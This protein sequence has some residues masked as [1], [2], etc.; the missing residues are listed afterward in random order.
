[1]AAAPQS[2]NLLAWLGALLGE[3]LITDTAECAFY[4]GD[5]YT[6]GPQPLAVLRPASTAELS[7]AVAMVAPHGVALVPRG[8]GMSYTGGYV[9]P[10]AGALIVDLG[11][12]DRVLAISEADMTATVEAGCTWETLRRAL[13]PRKLRAL[14]WGTLSGVKATVGGGMSQNGVFWGARDGTVVDG[15]LSFEVVLADGRIVSTGSSF[16]RPFGPD[17]TGL[18]GADAGA[19]GSRRPP[20]CNW[21]GR[22][23]RL[24]MPPTRSTMPRA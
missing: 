8:G 9:A 17:L 5:I 4:A 10:A 24:A 20:P 13:Q 3:G 6:R 14:A 16:F 23:M 18:F 1:M 11:R 7:A 19:L 22:P 21:C 2:Q 15:A 12:M